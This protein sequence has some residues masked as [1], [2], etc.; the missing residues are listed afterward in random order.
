MSYDFL[1]MKSTMRHRP[2]RRMKRGPPTDEKRQRMVHP[3]ELFIRWEIIFR[4]GE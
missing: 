4:G 1:V 3:L 2:P